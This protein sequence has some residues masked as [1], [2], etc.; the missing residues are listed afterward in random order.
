MSKCVLIS[1]VLLVFLNSAFGQNSSYLIGHEKELV[2]LVKVIKPT[3]VSVIVQRKNISSVKGQHL[4][5]WKRSINTG[6][7]VHK[8][9]YIMTTGAAVER[10]DDIL[11]DFGA[12]EYY[13]GDIVGIDNFSDIA[14]IRVD[15]VFV[16]TAPL[17][18]S[19]NANPGSWVLV[20]SNRNSF[21]PLM[22]TGIINGI[23]E[24]DVKMQVTPSGVG[25]FSGGAVF[26]TKGH[27]LGF[28]TNPKTHPVQNVSRGSISVIPI[29][30]V[31]TPVNQLIEYGEIR[32]S[33]LGIYVEKI[34]DGV[35]A[36]YDR[37]I[38]PANR[39]GI[40]IAEVY[41]NSPAMDAGIRKGDIL[42]AVN[43]KSMNHPIILAD[44]VTSLPTGTQIK[45]EYQRA[46]T[47][48][49]VETVLAEE[50]TINFR[51]VSS[52][53]RPDRMRESSSQQDPYFIQQ[54]ILETERELEGHRLRLNQLKLL[55]E[56][57]LE[58]IDYPSKVYP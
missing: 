43:G 39:Q 11:I 55:W 9:G 14:V 54:M 23:R 34:W 19:D 41:P 26:A 49:I 44:F 52:K 32:R 51:S 50:P 15:S 38:F 21:L 46:D 5:D 12:G 45:I 7:V 8:D 24:E 1:S 31:K 30:R 27:L 25:N 4:I 36:G 13:G 16:N 53:I 37:N 48:S 18:D 6:V 56:E 47:V 33:W 17:G 58:E 2:N 10:A 28:V 57:K 35:S 29:N 3:V 40:V 22:T 20:L 42:R